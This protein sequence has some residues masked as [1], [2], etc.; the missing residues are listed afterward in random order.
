MKKQLYVLNLFIMLLILSVSHVRGQVTIGAGFEPEEGALLELKQNATLDPD[1]NNSLS[2][3]NATKGLL[4]PK[5]SV[6][7][8]DK[9]TP[10]YGG[11]DLGSGEWSDD[12]TTDQK[13]LATGMVVYNINPAAKNMEVGLYVWNGSRW[14]PCK[15]ENGS[16]TGENAEFTFDCASAV[17]HG[18]YLKNKSLDETNYISIN[19]FVTK[20]GNYQVETTTANPDNKMKF[21]GSGSLLEGG[22]TIFLQG[23]GTPTQSGMFSFNITIKGSSGSVTCPIQVAV[24]SRASRGIKIAYF[25]EYQEHDSRSL[26]LPDRTAYK[27]LMN[28]DIFGGPES[29]CPVKG[30]ELVIGGTEKN[31]RT[32]AMMEHCTK[33]ADPVDIIIIGYNY[34]PNNTIV[35]LL[36]QYID[37]NGVVIYQTDHD[38]DDRRT[39]A[40]LFLD[41]VFGPGHT[42][43][44]QAVGANRI[45]LNGNCSV[46]KGPY[47]DL[48]GKYV[49]RD[50]GWNFKLTNS[51]YPQDSP[52]S[53]GWSDSGH[54]GLIHPTLGC[55]FIGDGGWFSGGTSQAEWDENEPAVSDHL[56]YPVVTRNITST[57][58]GTY[59]A[60][61]F[62]NIMMWAIEYVHEKRPDGGQIIPGVPPSR[63]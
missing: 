53:I 47:I 58:E 22:Q 24:A 14:I 48:T 52:Y 9:L 40:Q 50:G 32:D 27:I 44:P 16:S 6:K 5:V 4:F 25:G 39:N 30:M 26:F 1:R 23:S 28:K 42:V 59:N 13:L 8:R 45:A 46:V 3:E 7:D 60:H 61:L 43:S 33:G 34:R 31:F 36:K 18:N 63:D 2:L 29:L 38:N 49:Q 11:S 54:R 19:V 56:G 21:E 10:L 35:N 20:A 57:Q 62:T 17:V 41:I 51:I 15:G 12:S 55:I 37:N